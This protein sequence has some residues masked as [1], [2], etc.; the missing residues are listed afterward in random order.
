[1]ASHPVICSPAIFV[2]V[3][4]GFGADAPESEEE[5]LPESPVDG[6]G[7]G[8]AGVVGAGLGVTDGFSESSDVVPGVLKT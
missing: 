8:V 7:V 5:L 6:A 1:M 4:T 3:S 2:V